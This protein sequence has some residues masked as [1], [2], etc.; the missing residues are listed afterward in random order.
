M[1]SSTSRRER[2]ANQSSG[3][4]PTRRHVALPTQG[5]GCPRRSG[6]RPA[7]VRRDGRRRGLD[8][9]HDAPSVR[10][11]FGA[12]SG[13][14]GRQIWA[15]VLLRPRHEPEP[16]RGAGV[17]RFGHKK[18]RPRVPFAPLPLASGADHVQLGRVLQLGRISTDD[19]NGHPVLGGVLS[20][21]NDRP[22]DPGD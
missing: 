20:R 7:R 19:L 5:R 18:Q 1:P 10:G 8:A 15:A 13:G 6:S 11:V 22:V 17:R 21:C 12:I 14:V 2:A 4:R 9:S 16:V 3:L